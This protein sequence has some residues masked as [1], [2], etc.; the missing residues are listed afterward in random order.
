MAKSRKASPKAGARRKTARKPARAKVRKKVIELRPVR[1]KLETH[2]KTLRGAT[3]TR[4][5]K[6]A[7]RRLDRALAELEAICGAN[8][9]IPLA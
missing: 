5:V 1:Q 2:R 6:Y 9:I 7:I 4:E 8:M 3:P